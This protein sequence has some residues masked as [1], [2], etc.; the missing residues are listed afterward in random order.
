M[1]KFQLI[2]KTL[3]YRSKPEQT[4]TD[5]RFL[6][7]PTKNVLIYNQEKFGIRNGYTRLGAANTS[8][9][10]IRSSKTWKT[11]NGEE[12]DLRMYD[13]EL[14]VYLG[15]IDETEINAWTRVLA[16]WSTTKTMRFANDAWWDATENIDLMPWVIGDD[17]VYEWN[18]AV[19]VVDSITAVTVTKKGTTTWANNRFYTTRN[20]TLVCV[21]TGTEYVYTGGETTTTLTGIAD[22]TG[23]IA[24]DILVQKVVTNSNEPA[25]DRI[26]HYIFVNEN[27]VWL[28]SDDDNEVYISKNNSLTDYS[29]STPRLAGEGALLTLDAPTRGFGVVSKIPVIFSGQNSIY[30]VETEQIT[31]SSSIS[32]TIKVKKLKTGANQGAYNQE[33]IIQV[34]NGIIYLSNEPA[35]RSFEQTSIADEP[36]LITLS[37][38]IK[39]DFDSADFTNACGVWYKNAVYLSE[40]VNSKVWIL[41]Y[42]QNADGQLVRFWQPPQILPVRS[43]SIISDLLYGH[44][45][46]VPETYKLFDGLYDQASDDSKL[47][48][49]AVGACS[50]RSYGDKAN[51]KTFDEFYVE[52][53]IARNTKIN[54]SINYDFGGSTQILEKEIDGSDEDIIEEAITSTSLGTQSMGVQP[55]GG[56]L[57]SGSNTPKFRIIFEIPREDFYEMQEIYESNEEDYSWQIMVHGANAKIS[58]KIDSTIRK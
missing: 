6:V 14:E 19:A 50:Y 5:V 12:R 42:Q 33:T 52:G 41:N 2:D 58:G 32:E 11:S 34:G 31:V 10:P 35:L 47:P 44:S 24:G 15:T 23:L 27:Q 54:L 28:G 13:D 38:P 30:T 40:P 4:Q 37:D 49:H 17:N 56:S 25:S 22:T 46:S 53:A 21:R 1:R 18:G 3:E 51:L 55:L 7:S 45:N 20:K 8:L 43:F 29:Q 36:T 57:T 48:I 16:S 26:N 9:T 39:P